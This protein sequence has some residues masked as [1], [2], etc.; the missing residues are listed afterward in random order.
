MWFCDTCEMRN[1]ASRVSELQRSGDESF[2]RSFCEPLIWPS[3][4]APSR[5]KNSSLAIQCPASPGP[6]T[7]PRRLNNRWNLREWKYQRHV[8]KQIGLQHERCECTRTHGLR[9]ASA[10]CPRKS[11]A[12]KPVGQK[13]YPRRNNRN[14]VSEETFPRSAARQMPHHKRPKAL[15][16]GGSPYLLRMRRP[17]VEDWNLLGVLL[18]SIILG[19]LAIFLAMHFSSQNTP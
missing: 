3:A 19:L 15:G 7:E 9:H 11:A 14:S 6:S 4:T 18:V 8:R 13:L 16:P 5:S 12:S 17:T 10:V 1:V 2:R